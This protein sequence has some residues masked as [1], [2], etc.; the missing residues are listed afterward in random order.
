MPQA[1]I[2][3]IYILIATVFINAIFLKKHK[4]FSSFIQLILISSINLIITPVSFVIANVFL[5]SAPN[6]PI[7][8]LWIPT[9]FVGNLLIL[10]L[11]K[12]VKLIDIQQIWLVFSASIISLAFVWIIM[13]PH[14]I[15]LK[16]NSKEPHIE[17]YMFEP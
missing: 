7:S 2:N 4:K 16:N 8:F 5:K 1:W 15:R 6:E 10:N 9:I 17:N 3:T 12:R 13:Y 14:N 11:C